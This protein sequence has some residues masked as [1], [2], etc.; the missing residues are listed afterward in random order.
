MHS[1]EMQKISRRLVG[2][3]AAFYFPEGSIQV[4]SFG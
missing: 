1:K 3:G 4:V 2:G